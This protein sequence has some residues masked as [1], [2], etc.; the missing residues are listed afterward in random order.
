MLEMKYKRVRSIA[1]ASE[2]AAKTR[3]AVH[4]LCGGTD[5]IVKSK[6][7]K[8]KPATWI[9]VSKLPEL[10]AIADRE[11]HVYVGA[12]TT[13]RELEF[14][15]LVQR[16]LPA[17]H[18]AVLEV[19]SPQIRALGTLGG[20]VGNA[21]PAGDGIPPLYAYGAQI[22]LVG[23]QGTRTVTAETFF[24]GPGRTV[25]APGE[26]IQGFR[27][28]KRPGHRAAFLKLGPRRSLSIA[29][30]SL[31]LALELADGALANVRIG[32]GAVGPTVLRGLKAEKFLEGKRPTREVY[33]EAARLTREEVTPITDF[34]STAGYRRAMSGALLV[35]ALGRLCGDASE[36]RPG[37]DV[38]IR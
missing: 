26:I 36:K 6:A 8:L 10:K 2:L 17:L 32:L 16:E 1:E 25:L 13:Y 35:R 21:S 14:S 28:P 12:G 34:R 27:L 4:F 15:P 37:F 23:P 19:G 31:A 3:G 11:T 30:V 5:L 20:N 9:D 24:R 33:E 18:Q 22:D 38:D 7:G 29:K